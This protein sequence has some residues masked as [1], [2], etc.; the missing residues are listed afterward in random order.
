MLQN[1][2]LCDLEQKRK[3]VNTKMENRLQNFKAENKQSDKRFHPMF[4]NRKF[5]E[6]HAPSLLSPKHLPPSGSEVKRRY[7]PELPLCDLEQKRRDG[8]NGKSVAKLQGG[9]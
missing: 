6:I 2:L 9:R 3:D 4:K 1:F 7:A 8:K 5:H